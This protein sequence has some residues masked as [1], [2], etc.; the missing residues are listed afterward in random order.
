MRAPW[1]GLRRAAVHFV[2]ALSV[3]CVVPTTH[4][5]A[6]DLPA[7]PLPYLVGGQATAIWQYH[8]TFDSRYQGPNS[9]RPQAEDA[10]SHTYTLYTGVRPQPWLDLYADPEMVRGRGLSDALGLAG[11][12]NGEVIRNPDIG[13]DPYLARL[14][15][16]VTLPLSEETE[17]I[18]TGQLQIAGTRPT[19]RLTVT[20]GIFATN[21]LFDIN[22]YA[23]NTRTQFMN[24]A[25][26]TNAAYDFAADTRGYSR[27][28][29]V[30]WA[31]PDLAVRA[32]ILQMPTVANGIDLDSD[33]ASSHGTQLEGEFHRA[34]LPD[35]PLV[36]RSF[37]FANQA[38]M[39]DYRRSIALAHQQG[40]VPDITATRQRGALKYGFGFNLEQPLT[41]DGETGLF[42][43]LGWNDGATESF[44]FTEAERSVSLGAQIAGGFWR[45]PDDRV[46]VAVVANELGN[47]HA[48]YLGAGGRGFVLG[49]GRLNRRPE[50]I[51]E[52]YYALQLLSWFAVSIDY[53][54][55]DNPGYN[56]DRGP[57]SVVSLRGHL[58]GTASSPT[59]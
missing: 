5:A 37:F 48:D 45:R 53:Q 31:A 19:H 28:I 15:L 25:L 36:L 4:A 6:V 29:A 33:V 7:A 55:I 14:F 54:F 24:W 3:L 27:G 9:L 10:I 47:A 59:L 52:T 12:T 43:R 38:R 32:G 30:E 22:R 51:T 57:V 17:Q 44:A 40:G 16:R 42:A 26:I 46:G 56:R 35:R 20:L 21:D 58:E 34:L 41:A 11:F 49:D 18:E 23:N 50:I 1:T 8:S 13:T 2:R 39:G